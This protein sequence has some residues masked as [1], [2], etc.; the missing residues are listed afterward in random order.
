[1]DMI[2]LL[3]VLELYS[4][5]LETCKLIIISETIEVMNK[6]KIPLIIIVLETAHMETWYRNRTLK[7]NVL[8]L[9]SLTSFIND[10]LALEWLDHFI[11]HLSASP[12][13]LEWTLLLYNNVNAHKTPQFIL[14]VY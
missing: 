2:V 3:K 4:I 14:K 9:L 6:T 8:I 11:K 10:A 7:D 13:C 5:S 12:D 1:M